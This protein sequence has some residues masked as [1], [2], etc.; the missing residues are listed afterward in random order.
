MNAD[1]RSSVDDHYRPRSQSRANFTSRTFHS[2]CFAYIDRRTNRE[3]EIQSVA[4]QLRK[5]TSRRGEREALFAGKFA[6]SD[7]RYADDRLADLYGI[8]MRG[9]KSDRSAVCY[10]H[11]GARRKLG[12]TSRVVIIRKL[13]KEKKGKF[14]I[15]QS[16]RAI[17]IGILLLYIHFSR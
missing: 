9:K 8:E 12:I 15:L 11:R 14:C 16:L 1:G 7:Q 13:C 17:S 4:V 6:I 2:P 10:P 5:I 3:Y